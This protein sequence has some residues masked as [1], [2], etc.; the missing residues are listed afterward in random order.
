MSLQGGRERSVCS[1]LTHRF[2]LHPLSGQRTGGNSR[3]TAKGFELGIHN[4]PLVVH[5]NLPTCKFEK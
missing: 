3:A 4:L 1:A 2:A 5:L